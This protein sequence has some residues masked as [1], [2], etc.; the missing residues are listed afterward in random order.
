MTIRALRAA[1]QIPLLRAFFGGAREYAGRGRRRRRPGLLAGVASCILVSGCGTDTPRD[2][3]LVTVD[4]LRADHLGLY[5]YSRDTS[6]NLDRWFQHAAIFERAYSAEANTSPS[7]VSLLTGRL[8]QD[9]G[10]R[11]LYQ[12]VPE[13]TILLPDLLSPTYQTAAFVSNPVLS[14]EAMG[15]SG[16]FDHYDDFVDESGPAFYERNARRTTDAVLQWLRE[17]RDRGRPLFLW[18][19]YIDPHGPYRAPGEWPRKFRHDHP[20]PIEALAVPTYQ[21][22]PEVSDGL[23]YVD[24]Y[25]EE[26]RYVDSEIGRLLDA[27]AAMAPVDQAL[28]VFTADHGESM[29]DHEA[30]FTHG[31]HV[32]EEIVRVPLMV[33]G[34]TVPRG[35][36]SQVTS[37][38]DVAPTILAFTGATP[39]HPLPGSDLRE[40]R[41]LPTDRVVFTEA[42][43]GFGQ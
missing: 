32:Y 19:H 3:L 15:I 12:L 40:G 4:T 18:V 23:E 25:D 31:H 5:G 8:P 7:V 24:R 36:Y 26:I 35:R 17:H 14:N 22:D 10:V 9:H 38:S 27:Y 11:L 16:R 33:R 29:M 13:G 28:I 41:Y 43:T 20:R 6:P 1:A 34:P 21:R 39:H 2:V 42:T 30:W 37:G